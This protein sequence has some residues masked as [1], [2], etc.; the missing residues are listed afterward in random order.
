LKIVSVSTF[1]PMKCG[2]ATYAKYLGDEIVKQGLDLTIIAEK[3]PFDIKEKEYNVINCYSRKGGFCNDI[4]SALNKLAGTD[5]VHIQHA[6][7]L[8]PDK[9]EFVSLLKKISEKGISVL[10]TLHTVDLSERAFYREVSGYSTVVVHNEACV[11]NA[12]IGNIHVIPHGTKIFSFSDSRE[13][14][15]NGLGYGEEDFVFLFLGF[16]HTLKNLHTAVAA[17][18]FRKKNIKLIVAGSP[19]GNRWYNWFYLYL[20]KGLS[21]WNRNIKWDIGFADDEKIE[22]YLNCCDAVLMPYWQ[23]YSSASGIFHLAVGA[24]KPFICSDSPK[25]D[26]IKQI[27]S[28][29]PVFI[30]ALSITAWKKAM[31][32]FVEKP[33]VVDAVKEIVNQYR[34]A[35]SWEH[36]STM[37]AELYRGALKGGA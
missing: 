7:D 3:H 36:V 17:F 34:E 5:I 22:K 4:Y 35:T 11:K 8:F 2:I 31:S 10:V 28:G 27:A 20:C 23:K 24:G 32:M 9:K 16:I 1:P 29:I 33:E 12:G 13:V 25:F 14:A 30:P 21:F 6:P 37:H 15:R 18:N 26:E 19:G